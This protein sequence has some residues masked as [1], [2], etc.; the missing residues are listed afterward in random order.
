[1]VEGTVVRYGPPLADCVSD[2]TLDG[3]ALFFAWYASAALAII[4]YVAFIPLT[5]APFSLGLPAK[6]A[7][8]LL[9][10]AADLIIIAICYKVARKDYRFARNASL[11]AFFIGMLGILAAALA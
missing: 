8:I 3:Q 6:P 10:A 11:A 9:V 5:L 1:M 7:A 2:C 4:L